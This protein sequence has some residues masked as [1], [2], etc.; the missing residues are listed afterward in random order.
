[1][2]RLIATRMNVCSS[3]N[4]TG[5]ATGEVKVSTNVR[6]TIVP[7]AEVKNTQSSSAYR[8]SH[9]NGG[10]KP[11]TR[12]VWPRVRQEFRFDVYTV[13]NGSP[14]EQKWISFFGR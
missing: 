6:S 14:E 4:A 7:S 9:E 1:M 2:S 8:T 5:A 10:P 12:E 3:R 13:L 11:V